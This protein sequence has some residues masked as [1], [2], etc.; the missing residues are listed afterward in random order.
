MISIYFGLYPLNFIP[1]EIN[2]NAFEI[3]IILI[4][5]YIIDSTYQWLKKFEY[6]IYKSEIHINK[7]VKT[8]IWFLNF[9]MLIACIPYNRI[10]II[11][12]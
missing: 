9:V 11:L 6:I 8:Y 5:K 4:E 10:S 7:F 12:I 3:C 1:K 2:G